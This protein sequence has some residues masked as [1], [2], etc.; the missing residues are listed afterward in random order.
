M[1]SLTKEFD[2]IGLTS[3]SK[4]LES[5]EIK[6]LVRFWKVKC[7]KSSLILFLIFHMLKRTIPIIMLRIR[8]LSDI[9]SLKPDKIASLLMVISSPKAELMTL[10]MK[11]RQ[12]AISVSNHPPQVTHRS[13]SQFY[14]MDISL[15]DDKIKVINMRSIWV[16]MI[17]S[18]S[19]KRDCFIEWS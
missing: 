4:C 15:H 14:N 5:S 17:R 2:D 19:W 18:V 10:W 8:N 13:T 9:S 6:I 16:N 1:I 11:I 7:S 12:S 3:K